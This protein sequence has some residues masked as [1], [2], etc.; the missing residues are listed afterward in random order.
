MKNVLIFLRLQ[1]DELFLEWV[2]ILIR[3]GGGRIKDFGMREVRD[4]NKSNFTSVFLAAPL[5]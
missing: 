4:V 1:N 2:K 3:S 5:H